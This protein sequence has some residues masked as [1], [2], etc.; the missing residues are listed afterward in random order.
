VRATAQ[1]RTIRNGI[2]GN[3]AL[4]TL[5]TLA[6]RSGVT[7]PLRCRCGASGRLG[8]TKAADG[9]GGGKEEM[10]AH[11]GGHG[12]ADGEPPRALRARERKVVAV[13]SCAGASR[14][15]PA[16]LSRTPGGER[17]PRARVDTSRQSSSSLSDSRFRFTAPKR[18]G[19][20]LKLRPRASIEA[21]R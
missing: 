18:A 3:D 15:S 12:C 17:R 4:G 5:R 14:G 10:R 13:G 6:Q 2:E 1:A 9:S 21:N 20:S 19:N 8:E 16:L 11:R 7:G